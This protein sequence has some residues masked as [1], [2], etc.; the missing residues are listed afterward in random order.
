MTINVTG[1]GIV[2]WNLFDVW[3][4]EFVIEIPD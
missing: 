3:F 4:L 2:Y 1:L